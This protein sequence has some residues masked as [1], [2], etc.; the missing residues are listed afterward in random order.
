MSI[1]AATPCLAAIASR[2]ARTHW[3]AVPACVLAVF[4]TPA[5]A[6]ELELAVRYG[7]DGGHYEGGGVGLRLG[8]FWSKERGNWR[9]TLR[10]E[11]EVN[12][13]RHT[14]SA[15]GPGGM[16]EVG[17]IGLFRIRHGDGQF[18]PYAEVGLGGALLSRTRLGGKELSTGF[19]FSEHLGAGV[20]FAGEWFVGG[21]FSHYSNASIKLPNDGLDLKQVVIGLRF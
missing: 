14:D 7:Q 12:H 8:P 4:A 16:N 6:D 18:R 20:E 13:F 2:S 21:R 3:L 9:A 1:I 15:G 5:A 17:A 19:Q 11:L 10:P